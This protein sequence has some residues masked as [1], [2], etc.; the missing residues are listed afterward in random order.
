V[1]LRAELELRLG[2]IHR[3]VRCHAHPL[4][5]KLK[6]GAFWW[7]MARLAG[8][9]GLTQ[10]VVFADGFESGDSTAWSSAVP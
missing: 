2:S 8:W 7:M 10:P 1:S 3:R 9:D 6:G 4:L 5:C